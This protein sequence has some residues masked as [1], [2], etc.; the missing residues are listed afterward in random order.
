MSRLASPRLLVTAVFAIFVAGCGSGPSQPPTMSTAPSEVQP[1][2]T[3][4]AP[5]ASSRPSAAGSQA[6]I[7]VC[8]LLP[9][10][11]L[12]EVLGGEIAFAQSVPSGGW[13]AGQCAWNGDDSSFI[14][15]VGT[16]ASISAF[17]DPETANAEALFNAFKSDAAAAGST[18]DVTGIGDQA[19]LGPSGMA[20]YVGDT[21][22]EITR[23]RVTDDQ[24]E[25]IM[26]IA[27]ASI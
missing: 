16:A 13:A 24:L 7:D 2:D 22:V 23:L 21:Y 19:V 20:A 8:S 25:E 6:A 10:A 15:R 14:V 9:P 1:T 12:S 4:S 5:P 17:G 18:R 27:I 26:R 3:T 11:L